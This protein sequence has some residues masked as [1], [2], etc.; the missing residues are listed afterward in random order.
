MTTPNDKSSTCHICDGR[1]FRRFPLGGI[2]NRRTCDRCKGIGTLLIDEAPPVPVATERPTPETQAIADKYRSNPLGC[3]PFLVW[4]HAE[5]LERQRDELSERLVK[6]EKERR[7]YLSTA[8]SRGLELGDFKDDF[9]E[10]V[11]QGNQAQEDLAA[12]E[13]ARVQAEKDRDEW[14]SAYELSRKSWLLSIRWDAKEC[15][16]KPLPEDVAI[17][18]AHPLE[19]NRHDLY[20]EAMRLVG[21]KRSKSALVCLVNWMLA[22]LTAARAELHEARRER[23]ALMEAHKKGAAKCEG[24]D[25][26]IC[27]ICGE[28]ATPRHR[29]GNCP[30]LL[31][32][33]LTSISSPKNHE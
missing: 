9:D 24:S 7:E 29:S 21:A 11:K 31:R 22:D 14:K 17:M 27:A 32:E 25:L 30:K 20:E 23:D 6:S 3:E 19:T 2:R 5:T 4:N 18:A 33:Q 10:V 13:A 8:L 15:E 1:G 16:E 28:L 12:S 26:E